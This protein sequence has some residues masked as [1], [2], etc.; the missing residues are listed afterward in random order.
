MPV[1][2]ESNCDL[3]RLRLTYVSITTSFNPLG[4]NGRS[5]HSIQTSGAINLDASVTLG[6][7]SHPV[8]LYSSSTSLTTKQN[9]AINVKG[10]SAFYL[11]GYA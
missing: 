10:S 11:Y 9:P 2:G 8:L 4:T 5:L 6:D 7:A 3:P 1:H